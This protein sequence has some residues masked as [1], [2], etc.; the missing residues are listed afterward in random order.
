MKKISK[1]VAPDFRE[2]AKALVD[3]GH[4]DI[5]SIAKAKIVPIL[6]TSYDKESLEEI[7]KIKEILREEG[8]LNFLI[9]KD[10]DTQTNFDNELYSKFFHTLNSVP[11]GSLPIPLFYFP[12]GDRKHGIGH[13]G[14]LA[15]FTSLFP[16]LIAYAGVF[17]YPNAEML[18]HVRIIPH[19]Y[20]IMCFEDL[21]IQIQSHIEK[22]VPMM[23][24]GIFSAFKR[25]RNLF[26]TP[27]IDTLIT[28]GE[29]HDAREGK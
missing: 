5:K 24:R 17:H 10:I 15:D 13:H 7:K 27:E 25:K 18:H 19:R 4:Q 26:Y 22:W 14:E 2:R 23:E 28:G 20:E 8:F 11:D 21:L 9:V 6:F 29:P 3:K 1:S 12:P 16:N